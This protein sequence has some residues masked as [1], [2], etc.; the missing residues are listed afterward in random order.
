MPMSGST[1]MVDRDDKTEGADS[2][3]IVKS[4]SDTPERL[5][6]AR[7]APPHLSTPLCAA[8]VEFGDG[9]R[10]S[11]RKKDAASPEIECLDEC[12]EW[13]EMVASTMLLL[14]RSSMGCALGVDCAGYAVNVHG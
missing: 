4:S 7:P 11:K 3:R 10:A 6:I 12:E 8:V 9:A 1:G 13:K 5:P 14:V 2:K